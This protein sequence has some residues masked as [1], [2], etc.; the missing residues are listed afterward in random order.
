MGASWM[1]PVAWSHLRPAHHGGGW[2]VAGGAPRGRPGT[3]GAMLVLAAAL[4]R[5][6]ASSYWMAARSAASAWCTC[7]TALCAVPQD[8][9]SPKGGL[10]AGGVLGKRAG[11]ELTAGIVSV[12]FMPKLPASPTHA[13]CENA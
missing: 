4:L 1:A 12:P 9:M 11:G 7:A 3:R 13:Q 8:T 5:V 10:T 2:G 6:S